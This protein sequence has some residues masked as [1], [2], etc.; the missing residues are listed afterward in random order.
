MTW[1]YTFKQN[2]WFS[3]YS[4]Y[5]QVPDLWIRALEIMT[6]LVCYWLQTKET[7]WIYITLSGSEQWTT[8]FIKGVPLANQ[9]PDHHAMESPVLH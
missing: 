6:E 4:N 3:T 7:V 2:A 1:M 8:E 5:Q 9:V